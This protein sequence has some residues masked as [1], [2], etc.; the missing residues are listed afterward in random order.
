MGTH[1]LILP[2][3]RCTLFCTHGV[4]S[5]SH[6]SCLQRGRVTSD[7]TVIMIRED[8][9]RERGKTTPSERGVSLISACY[10]MC[11]VVSPLH[12]QW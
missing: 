11:I 12:G 5:L 7:A 2:A 9:T 1:R 10:P 3:V 6:Q 4:I 8:S